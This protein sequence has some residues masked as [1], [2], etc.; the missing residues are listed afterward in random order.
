M[1]DNKTFCKKAWNSIAWDGTNKPA[2]C[3]QFKES[4]KLND[5][6]VSEYWNSE[7][8][9]NVRNKMLKGEFVN[10]CKRCYD[11]EN[12][13]G[14]SLRLDSN[15]DPIEKINLENPVINK[16][17]ITYGNICNKTCPICRPY[18]SHLIGNEYKKIIASD[19][20]NVWMQH[21]FKKQPYTKLTLNE[22]KFQGLNHSN[23]DNLQSYL[24]DITHLNV[25]G[26]EVFL[27]QDL[28]ILLNWLIDNKKTGITLRVSSNGSWTEEYL[29]ALSKFENVTLCVSTEG[30]GDLYEL[31]RPPHNWK[32]F[33]DQLELLNKY[34]NI[35]I[36]IET[37][38][39][40]FNVHQLPGIAEYFKDTTI[41]FYRLQD[42]EYLGCH[43]CP[44][45]VL[46]ESAFKLEKLGFIDSANYLRQSTGPT[47]ETDII[48]F[49]EYIKTYTELK[50]INY[51]KYIPW[52]FDLIK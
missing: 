37:V 16:V 2:P 46:E 52:S 8:L 40:V 42:Q 12:L 15:N 6:T 9:S 21:K 10:G 33:T 29:T 34:K 47:R 26:G 35:K 13:L 17:H 18:R 20:N 43:L 24:K 25:S 19:A 23:L 36:R 7:W 28:H 50:N 32:W 51:Q 45:S 4:N 44:D 5:Y 22:I 41:Q 14:N 39:N 49:H 30:I 11:D 38:I 3:C 1:I 48:L 27:T 31:V